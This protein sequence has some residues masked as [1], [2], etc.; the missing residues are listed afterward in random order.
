MKTDDI[1]TNEFSIRYAESDAS[2]LIHTIN[3][4]KLA[5]PIRIKLQTLKEMGSEKASK[6]VGETLLLLIPKLRA[7]LFRLSE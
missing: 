5:P 2:L 6:W 1:L 3:D 4:G 7:E